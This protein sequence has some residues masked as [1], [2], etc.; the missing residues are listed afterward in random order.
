MKG[1]WVEE[2]PNVLWAYQ[3]T[4][5]R[6]TGETPFSMTYGTEAIILV[7]VSLSSSKVTG[8]M[9]AIMMSV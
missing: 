5:R 2:L 6:S 9:Q 3:T 4:L 8:F 1:N 7:E